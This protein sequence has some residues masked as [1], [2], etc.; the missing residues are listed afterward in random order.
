MHATDK[1]CHSLP[2]QKAK[3]MFTIEE[4][5]REKKEKR[6]RTV[7][8]GSEVRQGEEVVEL[9]ESRRGAHG[10]GRVSAFLWAVVG[11]TSLAGGICGRARLLLPSSFARGGLLCVECLDVG[12]W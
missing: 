9:A 10:D 4:R 8:R 11:L 7:Q 1:P 6:E 12:L 2:L 3:S 5:R